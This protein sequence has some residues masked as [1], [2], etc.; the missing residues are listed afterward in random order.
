MTDLVKIA[1][2]TAA[3][4]LTIAIFNIVISLLNRRQ[5]QAI[6]SLVDGTATVQMEQVKTLQQKLE[7]LQ[8]R[9]VADV[10]QLAGGEPAPPVVVVDRRRE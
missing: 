2:I 9:R 3:T 4:Q 5:G 6:H 1:L 10:K 8:E 7:T